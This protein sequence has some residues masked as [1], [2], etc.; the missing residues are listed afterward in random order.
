MQYEAK[1]L[2]D[3]TVWSLNG[4]L[5]TARDPKETNKQTWNYQ[6]IDDIT[7]A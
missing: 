2:H 6:G 4:P 5:N 7:T 3:F 1:W